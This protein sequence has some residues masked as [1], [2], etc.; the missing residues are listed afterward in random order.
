MLSLCLDVGNKAI[1]FSRDG[2]DKTRLGRIVI[3]RPA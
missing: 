2:F 3:Q 1:A